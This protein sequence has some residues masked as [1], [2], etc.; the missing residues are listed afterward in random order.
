M[1]CLQP[2]KRRRAGVSGSAAF[3]VGCMRINCS[4]GALSVTVEPN[5]GRRKFRMGSEKDGRTFA[6]VAEKIAS[7][8]LDVPSIKGGPIFIPADVL[9]EKHGFASIFVIN[10]TY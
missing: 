5:V 10:K 3:T 4:T 8:P 1:F 7:F 6:L 2:N 9:Q